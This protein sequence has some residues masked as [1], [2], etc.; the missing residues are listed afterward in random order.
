MPAYPG[1][2]PE[3]NLPEAQRYINTYETDQRVNYLDPKL[4]MFPIDLDKML[5]EQLKEAKKQYH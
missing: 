4:K 2:Q 5:S 1:Y 3:L